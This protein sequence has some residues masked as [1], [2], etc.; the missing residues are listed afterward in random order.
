MRPCF[1]KVTQA[2]QNGHMT[3]QDLVFRTKLTYMNVHKA[4]VHLMETGHVVSISIGGVMHYM[5]NQEKEPPGETT[6]QRAI[7]KRPALH[8][9]FWQGAQQ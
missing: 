7:R 4:L 5:Q 2:L 8:S 6:V 3:R 9:I 1:E